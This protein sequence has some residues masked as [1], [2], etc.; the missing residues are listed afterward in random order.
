MDKIDSEIIREV[1]KDNQVSFSSIAEKLKLSPD[2]VCRRF[3]RIR[4]SD[5]ISFSLA[6]DPTKLGYHGLV[7]LLIRIMPNHER[8]EPMNKLIKIPG[9]FAV[10]EIMGEFNLYGLAL[11]KNLKEF[12]S[13]VNKVKRLPTVDRVEFMLSEDFHLFEPMLTKSILSDT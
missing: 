9:M 4:K 11:V 10:V 12:I 2:T 6:F 8:N 13:L 1:F 3:E 7:F 5:Q